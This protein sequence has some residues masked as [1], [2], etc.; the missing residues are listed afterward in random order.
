MMVADEG[1]GVLLIDIVHRGRSQLFCSDNSL[2]TEERFEGGTRCRAVSRE[3][4]ANRASSQVDSDE[5]GSTNA[6][7][8]DEDEMDV[9]AGDSGRLRMGDMRADCRRTPT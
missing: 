5:V 7:D 8:A 9:R 3:T 4:V 1:R 2:R 6:S